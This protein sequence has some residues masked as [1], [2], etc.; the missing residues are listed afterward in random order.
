M[1]WRKGVTESGVCKKFE[2]RRI[3]LQALVVCSALADSLSCFSC[4][5]GVFPQALAHRA[6]SS[7]TSY[8]KERADLSS[9]NTCAALNL[10][11]GDRGLT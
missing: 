8:L 1:L 5:A 9:R 10:I 4:N 11:M 3:S 2:K 6:V 7:A